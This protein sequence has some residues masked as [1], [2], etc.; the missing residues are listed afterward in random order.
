MLLEV[1]ADDSLVSPMIGPGGLTETEARAE[2]RG[3]L[4]RF[5][6]AYPPAEKVVRMW[7][8]GTDTVYVGPFTWTVYESDDPRAGAMLWLEDFAATIRSTGLDVSIA[9]LPD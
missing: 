5:A 4:T 7:D 8:T 6:E 9:K 1:H 2:V 3:L